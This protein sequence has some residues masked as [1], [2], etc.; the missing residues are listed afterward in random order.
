ME[1]P[2]GQPGLGPDHS[3]KRFF[4]N[5]NK[6]KNMFVK[7]TNPFS[8]QAGLFYVTSISSTSLVSGLAYTLLRFKT[9]SIFSLFNV[10][11]LHSA[12]ICTSPGSTQS[13]QL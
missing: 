9:N 11:H 2:W 7:S 8:S 1:Q 3:G 13:G 5:N 4:P 6:N 12:C 10:S